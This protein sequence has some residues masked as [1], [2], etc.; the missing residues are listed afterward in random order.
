MKIPFRAFIPM[1]MAIL[2]LGFLSGGDKTSWRKIACVDPTSEQ[3]MLNAAYLPLEN[4]LF[5]QVR[6]EAEEAQLKQGA[7]E[8]YNLLSQNELKYYIDAQAAQSIFG[9]KTPLFNFSTP[10]I[11]SQY[12]SQLQPQSQ[13]IWN[14]GTLG[15]SY[16]PQLTNLWGWNTSPSLTSA[17]MPAAIASSTLQPSLLSQQSTTPVAQR[18]SAFTGAAPSVPLRW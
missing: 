13:S 4:D 3:G 16:G 1:F 7:L 14:L 18:I 2:S 9:I 5:K 8:F 15:F 17:S 6:S 10:T 11:W 12:Q